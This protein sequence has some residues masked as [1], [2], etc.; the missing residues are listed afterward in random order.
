MTE[1][2][3]KDRR[4][5]CG[6]CLGWFPVSE[7]VRPEFPKGIDSDI[8]CSHRRY[9][10]TCQACA[11]VSQQPAPF[12]AETLS[13]NGWIATFTPALT[14]PERNFLEQRFKRAKTLAEAQAAVKMVRPSNPPTVT[15]GEERRL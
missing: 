9:Q 11:T 8:N 2:T 5:K 7:M 4:D 13:I 10:P 3:S 15:V 14:G 1:P 12:L 6:T